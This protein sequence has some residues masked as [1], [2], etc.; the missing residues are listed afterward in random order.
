[1]GGRT[2][3]LLA[4]INHFLLGLG[5]FSR[6]VALG[7]STSNVP[8]EESGLMDSLRALLTSRDYNSPGVA[9]A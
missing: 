1:M 3:S 4:K 8:P 6:R 2:F 5:H 9:I 7:A